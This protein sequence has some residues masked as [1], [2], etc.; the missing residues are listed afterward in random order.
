MDYQALTLGSLLRL[1]LERLDRDVESGY[2]DSGLGF[3]PRFTSIYR[4]LAER[5][6]LRISEIV[7]AM[8]LSQPSITNSISA[9]QKEGLVDV[10]RGTD[11][12]ERLVRLSDAGEALASQLKCHWSR[13]ARA[14]A[15]LDADVGAD[16]SAVLRKALT[17]LDHR[18]FRQRIATSGEAAPATGQSDGA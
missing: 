4:L 18:P 11:A 12:R 2:R 13:T 8:G 10:R 1:L 6:E 15:S 17:E 7:E 14:A 5:G 3:R 16:I 9:M